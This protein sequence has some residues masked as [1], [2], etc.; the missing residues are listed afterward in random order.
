EMPI[1]RNNTIA[2][3]KYPRA[4]RLE[5][6]VSRRA[7]KTALEQSAQGISGVRQPHGSSTQ[8]AATQNESGPSRQ[9]GLV[10]HK[11]VLVVAF[12]TCRGRLQCGMGRHQ[13]LKRSGL[14]A[15]TDFEVGCLRV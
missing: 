11:N 4:H 5:L 3:R 14:I 15:N 2:H 10:G 1:S 7:Y 8:R 6:P 13:D 12:Y 9:T